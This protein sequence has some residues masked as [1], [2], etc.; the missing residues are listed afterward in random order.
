MPITHTVDTERRR[1][2]FAVSGT[3]TTQDMLAAV[4]T[5]VLSA[6]PGAYS[7]LSD[8]SA[9]ATPATTEQLQALVSHLT[10]YRTHFGGNRWAV[11]VGQP[12]S[13]GMMR[14]LGVFAERIPIQVGVF[15]GPAEAI[16]WL[17]SPSPGS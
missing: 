16:R 3:L 5:A 14:M 8:H 12:A 1:I 13:F 17:E 2:V 7:V 10:K 11:V 15:D 6:G 4:D 9:I